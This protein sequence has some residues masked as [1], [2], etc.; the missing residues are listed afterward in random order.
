M[1]IETLNQFEEQLTNN[2]RIIVKYG[3]E[4]C[5][6]CTLMSI[7]LDNFSKTIDI[8]VIEVDI[9]KIP[10]LAEKAK[11]KAIPMTLF[12][13][14]TKPLEFIYGAATFEK[15]QQKLRIF[16]AKCGDTI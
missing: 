7:T 15:L 5:Q 3:A 8:P 1:K 13:H 16:N 12:Y 11:I 2:S 4:W 9:D 14:N 6:S 10:E